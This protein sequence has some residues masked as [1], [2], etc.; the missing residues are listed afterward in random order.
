MKKLIALL[1]CVMVVFGL[2]SGCDTGKKPANKG[3][4]GDKTITIGIPAST[5]VMDYKENALT[6]WVEE[7]TGYE[8]EFQ[9]FASA[10]ADYG[11]QLSTMAS[12]NMEL[13]DILTGF[14]LGDEVYNQYGDDEYFIDLAPYFADK[15]GKSKVWWD[16]F[17]ELDQ[18]YQDTILRR[19][20]ND[21]GAIYAFPMIQTSLIDIQDYTPWINTEWLDAVGKQKPTNIDELYDV[22]VAFKNGDPNGNGK[23]DEIPLCGATSLCG[24]AIAWIINMFCYM[25]EDIYFNLDE[26]GKVY[27]PE[28]TD[29]YRE[30][31]KFINKLIKENLLPAATLNTTQNEIKT[32]VTPA[33]GGAAQVGI[34][35]CH[36]T[37]GFTQDHPGILAYEALPLWGNA[38]YTENQNSRTTYITSDCADPDAAWEVLMCLSSLE[39]SIRM[40]YGDQGTDW[41]WADEGAI[42]FMGIP[43]QYKLHH[44][45]WST[46]GTDNWRSVCMGIL[47]NAEQE[48]AQV[49]GE[50]SETTQHKYNMFLEMKASYEKQ[51]AEYNPKNV[52]PLLVR[53]SEEK[54]ATD[55]LRS[56]C[57]SYMSTS[58]SK[59][60][61]GAQDFDINND[62]DWQAYLN[63]LKEL[64]VD[65]WIAVA[66]GI[67]ERDYVNK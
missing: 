4:K 32:L 17:A 60:I 36:P 20:T 67:Y 31:L 8:L 55:Q 38:V 7:Q 33:D 26:N 24:D 50:I 59:F 44:D 15:E 40:R 30:A 29:E 2:L 62:A 3:E 61:T 12:A 21:D 42:S 16:R 9:K 6:K 10:A 28:M 13:P 51:I 54:A 1:L 46:Q 52:C 23:P 47:I 5:L 66:Q 37:L 18:D 39:G 19:I 53:N 64:K 49:T 63:K 56:D 35:V 41:D 45:V 34:V 25:N 43:A 22:L 65:T 58:R 27:L 48:G 57:I 14:Q 11:S